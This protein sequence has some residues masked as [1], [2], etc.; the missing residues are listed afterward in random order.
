M[1]N[2]ASAT[3]LARIR[4]GSFIMSPSIEGGNLPIEPVA[5]FHDARKLQ[6]LLGPQ[7][8]TSYDDGIGQTAAAGPSAGTLTAKSAVK[9][10]AVIT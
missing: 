8:M 9:S 1:F 6:G 5:V 3:R 2:I 4:S 10:P 7:Q